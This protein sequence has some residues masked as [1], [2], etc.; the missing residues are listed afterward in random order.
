M[1]RA[2]DPAPAIL[3]AELADSS[4]NF[5]ARVW[6]KTADYWGVHFDLIE[7]VKLAFDAG[8]I[9]IPFPQRDVH[10]HGEEAQ[11]AA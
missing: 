5:K 6:C 9:T 2:A 3:V 11:G 1:A 10:H 8:D 7:Q 4:V